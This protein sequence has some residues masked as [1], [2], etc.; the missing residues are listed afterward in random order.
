VVELPLWHYNQGNPQNSQET[1]YILALELHVP[2]PLS[3]AHRYKPQ[4]QGRGSHRG[5]SKSHAAQVKGRTLAAFHVLTST[6]T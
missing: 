4:E 6:L 1:V 2:V 5:R 3:L